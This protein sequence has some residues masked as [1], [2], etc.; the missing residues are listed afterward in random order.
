[1]TPRTPYE[2]LFMALVGWLEGGPRSATL[3]EHERADPEGFARARALVEDLLATLGAARLAP[4]DEASRARAL[5]LV[6][7]GLA[8]RVRTL[9]ARA[10]PLPLEPEIA[11]RSGAAPFQ[12]LYQAEGY[13]VDLWLS[14]DGS[15]LGQVLPQDGRP[16]L[17]GGLCSLEAGA[18]SMRATLEPDGSFVFDRF[19]AGGVRLV[20]EHGDVEI[21]LEGLELPTP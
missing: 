3:D 7:P 17:G 8:A 11:L 18:V 14:E 2:E 6:R 10:V 16:G 20:L 5:G 19:P 13:D 21:V 4:L 1:M 12:A 9:L 15:L